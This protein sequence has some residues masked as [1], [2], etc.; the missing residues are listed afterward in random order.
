[1]GTFA[2]ASN[3]ASIQTAAGPQQLLSASRPMT[4]LDTTNIVSFQT[5]QL[6]LN[7]EPP[8]A[9]ANAPFF[10]DTIVYQFPH[11]YAY[12]PAVWL[13][14][15]NNSA[16]PNPGTPALNSSNTVSYPNGDDDAGLAAYE[17]TQGTIAIGV[18]SSSI[19]VEQYNGGMSGVFNATDALL[20][21]TVDAANVYIHIMK[22]TLATVGGNIVPLFLIGYILNMRIYVFTEPATTSTY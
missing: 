5:I 22:R 12:I 8:Q 15:Q 18:S 1:M 3:G 4:K 17:A 9:P 2:V 19:A 20:Y 16:N 14:W 13:S 6:L 10:T 7:H 21:V 11:G